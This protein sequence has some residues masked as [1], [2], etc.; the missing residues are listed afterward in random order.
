MPLI[1]FETELELP[2]SKE[3][4][5]SEISIIHT[6]P[7]NLDANPPVQEVVAIQTTTATFQINNAKFYVLVVTL[8][9]ND[10]IKFAGN[11]KQRFKRTIS[12]NKYRSQITTQTKYNNLEDLIDTKFRNINRLFNI[13]N[14]FIFSFKNGNDDPTRDPFDQ[15]YMQL[16]EIKDFNALIDNKLF[17]DLPVKNRQEAYDNLLDNSYHQKYYKIIGI[18]L[19]NTS[20]P[21]QIIL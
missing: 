6:T 8:F 19:S 4:I 1:N 10:N 2:W 11:I 3:Y 20:I 21:Q 5:I 7:A 18:D 14:G 16:V 13:K 12:W 17:F 9:V 15:Y